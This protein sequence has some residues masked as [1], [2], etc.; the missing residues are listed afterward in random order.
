MDELKSGEIGMQLRQ[1]SSINQA[2]V[3]KSLLK[4][5]RVQSGRRGAHTIPLILYSCSAMD[6]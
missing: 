2:Y 6:Q 1:F 5:K 3:C 4:R